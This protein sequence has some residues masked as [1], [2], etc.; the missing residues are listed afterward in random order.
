MI[1]NHSLYFEIGNVRKIKTFVQQAH[2][3]R[4]ISSFG[5]MKQCEKITQN[6]FYDKNFRTTCSRLKV[7]F[8]VDC[9]AN[10][11]YTIPR[12]F[13][14]AVK[15]SHPLRMPGLGS[16]G[17]VV[18]RRRIPSDKENR[19]TDQTTIFCCKRLLKVTK[20]MLWWFL[21]DHSASCHSLFTNLVFVIITYLESLR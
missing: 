16:I 5:K 12:L 8:S 9:T 6:F 4:K 10:R 7:E 11:R 17:P 1:V 19:K 15:Y 18:L 13:I 14:H 2:D 20:H 21:N 3:V